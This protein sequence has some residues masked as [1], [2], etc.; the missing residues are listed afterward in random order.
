MQP[1]DW[2]AEGSPGR[3]LTRRGM[4]RALATAAA[5]VPFAG[6][7]CG[8]LQ[9]G[10]PVQQQTKQPVTLRWVTWSGDTH[11]MQQAAAKG[12]T[13]F[14]EKLP[15]VT[16]TPEP[17]W[18]GTATGTWYEKF[19]TQWVSG[20]GPDVIGAC[21]TF[22]PDWGKQGLLLNLD[23]LIKRDGRQVPVRDYVEAQLQVWQAPQ[24]GQFAL[25]MYL[26]TR[27]VYYNRTMF[28]RNGVAFPDTTW[29]WNRW[30]DAMVR[31]NEPDQQR[32]GWYMGL[33][34]TT[35][36]IFV[37]QHGG[38]LVDPKDDTKAAWDQP[39]AL[40]ALQWLHDRM[41]KDRVLAK[42]TDISALGI[43]AHIALGRGNLAMLL[44]GTWLLADWTKQAPDQADQWD[45]A[46]LPKGPV[47]RS[48]Y[49]SI[50][51]W[52]LWTGTKSKEESW[53]FMKFLQSDPWIEL[54][55]TIAGQQPARKSWQDR[56]VAFMKKGYPA[57]A[58]KHIAAATDATKEGYARPQQ[59]F[60]KDPP[61]Q[62]V[63]SDTVAAV[64]TRNDA[65]L[66]DAFRD[67]ARQVIAINA[68]P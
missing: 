58:D 5:S 53:E 29:D 64:F 38:W 62:K 17:Q 11:P 27:V 61:S 48:T 67:A 51:G 12:V 39:P 59:F 63:W 14:K 68:T 1:T 49:A 55:L 25:P 50:D 46:P 19:Y 24:Q 44:D 22:L 3:P 30:R 65:P 23:S 13:L 41:W 10:V 45:L 15:H 7:A 32:Y 26:G 47:Q 31:L 20:S 37:N 2:K 42:A 60:K 8:P 34:W 54:A 18:A 43:P 66:V 6:F 40:N 21:C 56:F 33:W 57:M 52:A 28:Q 4:C 16:V 9:P 35:M 36:G